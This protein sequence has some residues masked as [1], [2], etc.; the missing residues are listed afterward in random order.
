MPEGS[1]SNMNF[2]YK[3]HD[4]H[5]TL[6]NMRQQ[7]STKLR[8]HFKQLQNGHLLIEQG[9]EQKG[10]VS[11]WSFSAEN[12]HIITNSSLLLVSGP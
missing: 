8:G 9:L 3:A 6:R 11:I 1:S 2:H 12:M 4:S 5:L 7:S 10:R